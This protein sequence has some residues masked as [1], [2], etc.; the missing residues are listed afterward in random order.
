MK[1][2]GDFYSMENLDTADGQIR[3]TLHINVNHNIFNGHF[4]GQPVV[5][6]VC[7]MQMIREIF[8]S[9]VKKNVYV[10]RAAQ[11]KFLAMIDPRITT[12]LSAIIAYQTSEEGKFQI[13]ASLSGDDITF[14]KYK[15]SF[16]LENE[17]TV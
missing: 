9:V 4:P 17:R 2:L 3:A 1:L 8:E 11:A 14:F 6:G 12:S 10:R 5:P 13:N 7:M 16:E 15:A